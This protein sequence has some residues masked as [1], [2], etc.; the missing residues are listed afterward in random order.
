MQRA[1]VLPA[2]Q[3]F[4]HQ[5]V[6]E[7]VRRAPLA[8]DHRVGAQVPPE[9][10]GEVLRAAVQ[11]PTAAHL[12]RFRIHDED[13]AGTPAFGRPQRVDVDAVRTAVHRVRPRVAGALDDGLRLD[14]L[15]DFRVARIGLGVHNVHA[16]GAKAGHHQVAALHVRVRRVRAQARTARVPAEVVQL[17]ARVG[18]LELAHHLPVGLRFRVHV[19]RGERIRR[20]LPGRV[21]HRD[22]RQ[23]F[24]RRLHRHLR[25]RVERLIGSPLRHGVLSL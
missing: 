1:P 21:Q 22:V 6:F 24:R 18:H 20:A 25:R 10:V 7:H 11:F 4:G 9:I 14:H 12:E 3:Q 13:A 5:P 23:G 17:I 8:G 16:R 2:Q 19:D 15:R